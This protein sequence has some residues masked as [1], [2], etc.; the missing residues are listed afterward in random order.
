MR[1][2]EYKCARCAKVFII[3]EDM[4]GRI[5]RCP[6]CRSKEV[7][8]IASP[9]DTVDLDAGSGEQTLSGTTS[10]PKLRD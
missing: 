3:T 1:Y 8:K 10:E 4:A 5:I 9:F 6:I 7:F 2:H